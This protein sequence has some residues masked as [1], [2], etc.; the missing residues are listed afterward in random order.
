MRQLGEALRSTGLRNDGSVAARLVAA[1][2][3]AL[4]TADDLELALKAFGGVLA[5]GPWSLFLRLFRELDRL[6]GRAPA[7]VYVAY[8]EAAFGRRLPPEVRGELENWIGGLLA[9]AEQPEVSP[10]LLGDSSTNPPCA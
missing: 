10:R 8:W 2:A 6:P 7:S 5:E 1:L 9:R 4:R 3:S